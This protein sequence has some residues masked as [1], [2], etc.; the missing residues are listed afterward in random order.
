[1]DER[2]GGSC[3]LRP[4]LDL[5]MLIVPELVGEGVVADARRRLVSSPG[6]PGETVGSTVAEFPGEIEVVLVVSSRSSVEKIEV[7]EKEQTHSAPA[8]AW[9]RVHDPADP[10]R[11]VLL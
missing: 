3:E 7:E 2:R 10:V 6:R 1:V 11:R 4:V 8:A 5:D 9:L